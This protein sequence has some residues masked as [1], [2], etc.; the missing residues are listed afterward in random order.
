MNSKTKFKVMIFCVAL[1]FSLVFDANAAEAITTT[2]NNFTML[3]SGGNIVGGTNDVTFSWDGTFLTSVA[4]SGQASNAT[5]TSPQPF[6]GVNWFAHDVA[7]YGPGTYTIY[8]NCPPGSPGCGVGTAYNFTVAPDQIAAH[9]L[10]NWGPNLNID[11][12]DIWNQNEAFGPSPMFTGAKKTLDPWSGVSTTAWDGMSIDWDGNGINGAA[13]IDGPFQGF[14][15]NFN[16]IGA[17]PVPAP[18]LVPG[19]N[20]AV[21]EGASVTLTG[22]CTSAQANIAITDCAWTYIDSSIALTSTPSGIGSGSASATATFNAP[23]V[24]Q[25][26]P[27]TFTLTANDGIHTAGATM[28]VTVSKFV[29]PP[30]PT[31]DAGAAQTVTEG[32]V[33]TLTGSCIATQTTIGTC[34]WTS[35]DS[36]INLSQIFSGLGSPSA[37]AMVT[38]TA[39]EVIRSPVT[40]TLAATDS[41][42]ITVTGAKVVTIQPAAVIPSPVDNKINS[43]GCSLTTAPVRFSERGDWGLVLGFFIWLGVWRV[44]RHSITKS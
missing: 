41:N 35:S 8:S 37:T 16:V 32:D 21:I 23:S 6:F 25:D 42:N 18:V 2:G 4:T 30:P 24:T 38:F 39:P 15:A 9:M 20:Q 27:Y 14:N 26:T 12:V 29:P 1:T 3:D 19:P 33:V 36:T 7:V 40:F 43:S 5:L 44:R 13:M 11:V 17:H 28:I 22:S 31:A 34:L 10:F